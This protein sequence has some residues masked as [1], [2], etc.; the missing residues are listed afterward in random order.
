MLVER[1]ASITKLGKYGYSSLD[2]ARK[3]GYLMKS[4]LIL[5]TNRFQST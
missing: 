5:D 1:G 3:K 2:I 4:L